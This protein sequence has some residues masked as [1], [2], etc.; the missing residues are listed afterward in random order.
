MG[1]KRKFTYPTVTVDVVLIAY[2]GEELK[3]LLIQRKNPPFEGCWAFPGGFIELNETLAESAVRELAEETSIKLQPEE[4]IQ[5]YTAGDPGRDPRG[6]TVSVVFMAL[7]PFNVL[8][9]VAAD[10]ARAIG[11]FNIYSP[12]PLAFDHL[13]ILRQAIHFLR[14]QYFLNLDEIANRFLEN[15]VTPPDLKKLRRLI[16]LK[17]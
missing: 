3:M 2:D 9:P 13:H 1:K 15:N 8:K 7:K 14:S 5:F 6:R 12:P 16:F 10:D 4:L 17:D 11:W